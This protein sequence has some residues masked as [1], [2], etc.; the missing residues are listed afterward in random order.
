[1]HNMDMWLTLA[2]ALAGG[3]IGFTLGRISKDVRHEL[4]PSEVR[5]RELRIKQM[6]KELGIGEDKEN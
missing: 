6:E 2:I 4:S 5:E 3:G 1:M